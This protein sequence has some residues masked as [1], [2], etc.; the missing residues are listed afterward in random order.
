MNP[1]WIEKLLK[2][3]VKG[4]MGRLYFN[5]KGDFIF[6]GELCDEVFIFILIV[7]SISFIVVAMMYL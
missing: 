1:F 5:Y 7:L 6:Y 4:K 2:N 3:R